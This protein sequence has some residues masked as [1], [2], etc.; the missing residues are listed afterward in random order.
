[1]KAKEY[2]AISSLSCLMFC[3]GLTFTCFTPFF[4][5]EASSRG[6]TASEYS[7]VVGIHSLAMLFFSPVFGKYMK[8]I[9]IINVFSIGLL[10]V[11]LNFILFGFLTFVHSTFCFLFL[12][13]LLRIF[14]GVGVSAVWTA[15]LSIL[16]SRYPGGSARG[17]S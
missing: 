14:Q 4:P 8:R 3:F 2:L 16:L 13:Y 7:P 17:C 10:L 9:G 5:T 11:C 12:A 6:A 1:M 15:T